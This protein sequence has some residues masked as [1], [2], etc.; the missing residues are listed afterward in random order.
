LAKE[1]PYDAVSHLTRLIKCGAIEEDVFHQLMN[2]TRMKAILAENVP[3]VLRLRELA[4]YKPKEA[5]GRLSL[6]KAVRRK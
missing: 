6:G 1:I 2:T 3:G 4:D 5:K